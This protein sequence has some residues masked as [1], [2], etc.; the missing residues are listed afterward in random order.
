MSKFGIFYT[1]GVSTLNY[2]KPALRFKSDDIT[3]WHRKV[4]KLDAEGGV[5]S[6][7]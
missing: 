2:S 3:V 5:I 6:K 4:E 1:K 7:S